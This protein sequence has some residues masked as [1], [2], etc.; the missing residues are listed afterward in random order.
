MGRRRVLLTSC[1]IVLLCLTIIV[2][3]TWA[4]F[5]NDMAVEH[6][7]KAGDLDITLHRV[8]LVK[9][10]L[11]DDGFLAEIS[12]P[13]DV[14]FTNPNGKNIFDFKA[15]KVGMYGEIIEKGDRVVPGSKYTAT[16]EISNNSD[17][18]FGYWVEIVCSDTDKAN[19]EDLAKQLKVTVVTNYD[20]GIDD[21]DEEYTNPIGESLE[22][23]G[24]YEGVY[25]GV[26][27]IGDDQ[28]FTVCVEFLDSFD[29]TRDDYND[30][31]GSYENGKYYA[32]DTAQ[33]EKLAFDLVVHAVQVTERP[34]T[35]ANP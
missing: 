27:G 2:G 34:A 8:H 9:N 33:G 5:T 6:L 13:D 4:L 3:M 10:D 1:A 7:L 15:D 11:D 32:N 16:M 14:D 24:E 31:F 17:V 22:V 26:L 28:Q 21:N 20:D 29:T 12:N 18:A 25:V 35:P 30:Y 19:G 23:K